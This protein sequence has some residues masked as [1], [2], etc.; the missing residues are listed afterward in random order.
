MIKNKINTVPIVYLFFKGQVFLSCTIRHDTG[1]S[2]PR[3]NKYLDIIWE[4]HSFV[5]PVFSPVVIALKI[6]NVLVR[7][8]NR[9]ISRTI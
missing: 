3:K 1:N 4:S 7:H 2:K 8:L 6:S 9:H 5:S